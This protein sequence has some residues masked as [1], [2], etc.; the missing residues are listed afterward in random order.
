[1][2]DS[3]WSELDKVLA[4]L[5]RKITKRIGEHAP[6]TI[7]SSRN[8]KD[9]VDILL[10]AGDPVE[11]IVSHVFIY[12]CITFNRG[13]RLKDR[14]ERALEAA[15]KVHKTLSNYKIIGY[16]E[17]L[18]L[19]KDARKF[20]QSANPDAYIDKIS[21]RFFK[22]TYSVKIEDSITGMT[23]EM[24]GK[25]LTKIELEANRRLVHM[26][27]ADQEGEEVRLM[28]LAKAQQAP[29]PVIPPD[30]IHIGGKDRMETQPGTIQVPVIVEDPEGNETLELEDIPT[31]EKFP[32]RDERV[33]SVDYIYPEKVDDKSN[34]S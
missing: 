25:D 29:M 24:S 14:I 2:K 10:R 5:A 6:Y 4:E 11:I 30:E 17:S 28:L 13:H 23:V 12:D 33:T 31:V 3:Q 18:A 19:M 16:R 22:K 9:D 15:P 1:M 20:I 32:S 21:S 8:V 26:I 7:C 27:E 34:P